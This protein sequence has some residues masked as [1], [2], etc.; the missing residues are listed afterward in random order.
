MV[1]EKAFAKL[2]GSYGALDGA[3][4]EITV[5]QGH[6]RSHKVAKPH[7]RRPFAG[8]DTACALT[9]LSG[10]VAD[11]EHLS[12]KR[13]RPSLMRDDAAL[14]LPAAGAHRHFASA[15]SAL[16]VPLTASAL[17]TA[18]HQGSSHWRR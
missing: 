1:V 16:G 18:S 2:H 12:D 17:P 9:M 5:T 15:S 10:G 13:G 8:G 7:P 3:S 6:T 4:P 11:T 14:R